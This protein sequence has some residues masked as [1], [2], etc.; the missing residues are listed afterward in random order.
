[1]KPLPDTHQIYLRPETPAPIGEWHAHGKA[2]RMSEA[3]ER[4]QRSRDVFGLL[5]RGLRN[6]QVT[7][8]YYA[9]HVGIIKFKGHVLAVGI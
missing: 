9:R 5:R 2:K 3:Q 4:V 8:I 7:F 1:M 6:A